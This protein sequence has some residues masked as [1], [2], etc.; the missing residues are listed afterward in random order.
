MQLEKVNRQLA[1]LKQQAAQME[2]E[3]A[4]LIE[5]AVQA[6]ALAESLQKQV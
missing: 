1:E 2:A 6:S 4:G 5:R 3:R